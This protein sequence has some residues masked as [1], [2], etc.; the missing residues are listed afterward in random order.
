MNSNKRLTRFLSPYDEND[1]RQ[2]NMHI[3]IRICM[4]IYYV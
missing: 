4:D 2:I 3:H 1:N